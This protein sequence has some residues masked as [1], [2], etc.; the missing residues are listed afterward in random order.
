MRKD[1]RKDDIHN[2][3]FFLFDLIW[4]ERLKEG[5][6]KIER[7][8]KKQWFERWWWWENGKRKKDKSR[9]FKR[10][11]IKISF[12]HS[13]ISNSNISFQLWVDWLIVEMIWDSYES[14][15]KMRKIKNL[16]SLSK[17]KIKMKI[18]I[19]MKCLLF[20]FLFWLIVFHLP[21]TSQLVSYK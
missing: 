21:P 13:F 18:K 11:K 17:F 8:K 12:I 14:E 6:R 1:K 9:Q 19:K 4:F 16:I 2:Y 7:R 3:S 20:S 15:K 5:N 10:I